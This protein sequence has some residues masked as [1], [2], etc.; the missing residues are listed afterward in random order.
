MPSFPPPE[1]RNILIVMAFWRLHDRSSVDLK[2][3]L[4]RD[5][6]AIF[7]VHLLFD[8]RVSRTSYEGVPGLRVACDLGENVVAIAA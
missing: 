3:E 1:S 4:L 5:P 6:D 2:A 7:Q 8:I